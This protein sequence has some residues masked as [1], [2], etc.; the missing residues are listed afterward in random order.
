MP[1]RPAPVVSFKDA[2]CSFSKFSFQQF[3]GVSGEEAGLRG[4][5]I[6]PFLH[7]DELTEYTWAFLSSI[8]T[9]GKKNPPPVKLV[10]MGI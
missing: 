9:I 7:M 1:L 5:K 3:L 10:E 4:G 2:V 6:Q 8:L